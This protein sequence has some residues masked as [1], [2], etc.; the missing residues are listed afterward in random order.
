[1]FDTVQSFAAPWSSRGN[2]P[3]ARTGFVVS[4][5]FTGNPSSVRP[6]AEA[7]ASAGFRVELPRLPGHGT[8]V[9][10]MVK[11]R[12]AD[13]RAELLAARER[14][15]RDCDKVVLAGL[16]MGGTLVL[17]LTGAEPTKVAGAIAINPAVL[18]REGIV[19]RL[20]PLISRVLPVVPASAAGLAKND[21]AKPGGDERAYA[22][23]PTKAADSLMSALPRVRAQLRGCSVPILVAY[24]P[25]DHSVPC[26]NA[27]AVPDLVGPGGKVQ[28]LIL[29]RSYH[30]ATLDYD[31]EKLVEASIRFADDL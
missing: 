19:A 24:S 3:R 8:H 25:Q 23:V 9:L 22:W 30:V 13:W 28:T 11:T 29:D 26:A 1:V 18:D 2:G 5:G 14:I 27:L 7:L 6:Y 12:Y 16:S 15:A 21:V 10:D 4:H 20:A 17:D 31:L